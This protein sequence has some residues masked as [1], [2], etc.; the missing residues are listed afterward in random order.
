M[1]GCP[2]FLATADVC[3]SLRPSHTSLMSHPGSSG[4]PGPRR[5]LHSAV[6]RVSGIPS[7]S[8]WLGSQ[9]SLSCVSLVGAF[10]WA[11]FWCAERTLSQ[12]G[13]GVPTSQHLSSQLPPP[14]TP[15]SCLSS[16]LKRLCNRG[17]AGKPR[18]KNKPS[19]THYKARGSLTV[20]CSIHI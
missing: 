15:R 16:L 5:S 6:L 8:V 19:L 9:H 12:S 3:V 1:P 7:T 18:R 11:V 13:H 17:S 10:K 14:V 20:E 4:G 2:C